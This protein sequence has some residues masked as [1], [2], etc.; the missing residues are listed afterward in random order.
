MLVHGAL[1]G[2]VADYETVFAGAKASTSVDN[3]V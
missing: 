3:G 2:T 1:K